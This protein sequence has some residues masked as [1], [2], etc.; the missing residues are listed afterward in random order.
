VNQHFDC[1]YPDQVR[2]H[3][4][5][6]VAILT[7]VLPGFRQSSSAHAVSEL[8]PECINKLPHPHHPVA[9]APMLYMP[10]THH[11]Q[12]LFGICSALLSLFFNFFPRQLVY[13]D[14]RAILPTQVAKA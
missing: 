14:S 8:T 7:L 11:F 12:R 5:P 2:G 10:V 13:I 6:L 4:S 3:I 1:S 9:L